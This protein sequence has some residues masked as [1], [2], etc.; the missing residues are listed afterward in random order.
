MLGLTVK[1][2]TSSLADLPPP[3]LCLCYGN[4]LYDDVAK[5]YFGLLGAEFDCNT[6][7]LVGD[8]Y[9]KPSYY[10]FQNLCK[11]FDEKITPEYIP[12]IF[13]PCGSLRINGADCATRDIIWGGLS[14]A[15]GGGASE[16]LSV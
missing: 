1:W 6:G 7:A 15:N 3:W 8:Y 12:V 10:A 16:P 9:E 4:T 2:T 14:K 5:Q 11:L 13:S